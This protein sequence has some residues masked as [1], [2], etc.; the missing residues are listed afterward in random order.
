M[1]ELQKLFQ[2]KRINQDAG[3]ITRSMLPTTQIREHPTPTP[4]PIGQPE[5]TTTNQIPS[6]A[7]PSIIYPG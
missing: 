4:T 5:A 7:F 6:Y 1:S 2:K 3:A